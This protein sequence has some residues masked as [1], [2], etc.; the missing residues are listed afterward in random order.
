MKKIATL[1]FTMGIFFSSCGGGQKEEEKLRSDLKSKKEEFEKL[2]KDIAEIE[3]QLAKFDTSKA[4]DGKPVKILAIA[5][6][7][8][9]HNIDIQGR[10]DAEESV[11]VSP[12]MPGLVKRV[13]VQPG[14]KVNAGEVL[15]EIDADA[16]IQQMNALKT[17]RDMAKEVY[18]RQKNLWDQKIGT[19]MQFL[20]SK[21]QYDALD[22]Q[23]LAMSEQIDMTRIKAPMSGTVDQVN[24]RTGEIA[25]AGFSGIV[26]VNTTKLR[27]KGEVAEAYIAQ[28]KIGSAVS[29]FIPDADKTIEATVTYSGQVVNKMNRTFNVE[30]AVPANEKDVLPNMIAV[31][32]INDYSQD[33]SIVAPLS[34]IQQTSDGKYFVFVAKNNGGKLTAEKR[35][36][37]YEKNYNG[38][39]LIT[40]GLINGD[41]LITDGYADLNNGDAVMSN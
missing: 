35:E 37:T 36:V 41:Q 9:V 27:V 11:T 32:K 38:M 4:N 22:K 18:D 8:F 14:D 28:V 12:Q 20:Q 15:A 2:R 3:L 40:S 33:N 25:A 19:E 5:P 39:A 16:M 10:V 7:R 6:T 30:V 26:I 31:M 1:L 29:I 24:I 13:N 34:A 17:Q 23:V 21:T